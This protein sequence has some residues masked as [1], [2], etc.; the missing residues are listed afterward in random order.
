MISGVRSSGSS[1]KNPDSKTQ[2]GKLE[3]A[4]H[5]LLLLCTDEDLWKW[6]SGT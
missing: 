2:R 1:V 6:I 3:E 5:L 4:F